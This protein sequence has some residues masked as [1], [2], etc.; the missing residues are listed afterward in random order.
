MKDG[1]VRRTIKAV[2]R[3]WFFA[4]LT[5]TRAI[6]RMRG[7][8]PFELR[9]GCEKCAACCE[10]PS[11]QVGRVIWYF[12]LMRGVFLAWQRHING[13]ILKEREIRSRTFVF[14]CTHFDRETRR[15]DSYDS[16]PGMCRDYPRALLWSASPEMLPRCGY[17]PVA[18]GAQRLMEALEKEGLDAEKLQKVKDRLHLE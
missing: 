15:C 16:R 3:L 13:F 6:W 2:A 9:G 17:R 1:V 14:E 8:K 10:A 12:P 11:I 7:E 4:N 18:P 5:G